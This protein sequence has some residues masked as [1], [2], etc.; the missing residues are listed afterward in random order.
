MLKMIFNG[1]LEPIKLWDKYDPVEKMRSKYSQAFFELW[2]KGFHLYESGQWNDAK[3]IFQQTRDFFE[4]A[5]D[6]PS[7]TLLEFME[8]YGF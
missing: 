8:G 5:K 7:L 3:E 4:E 1:K 2:K 6:G